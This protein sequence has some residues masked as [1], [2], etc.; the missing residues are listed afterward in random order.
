[1]EGGW[2]G[3]VPND[4]NSAHQAPATVIQAWRPPSG[5]DEGSMNGFL[6]GAAAASFCIS[7]AL[8]IVFSPLSASTWWLSYAVSE[9][10]SEVACV[11]ILGVGDWTVQEGSFRRM[12]N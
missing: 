4:T 11:D 6:G 9:S 5:K 8:P 3:V 7:G 12:L 10:G 2:W 1:M